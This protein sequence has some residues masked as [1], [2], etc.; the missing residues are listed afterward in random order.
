MQVPR[1]FQ[2]FLP[3]GAE[4]VRRALAHYV[5]EQRWFGGRVRQVVSTQVNDLVALASPE[6]DRSQLADQYALLFVQV[7][8]N[9]G[10]PEVYALPIAAEKKDDARRANAAAQTAVLA[11]HIRPIVTTEH[12]IYYEP[13]TE[14][15]FWQTL[16][17]CLWQPVQGIH[18]QIVGFRTPLWPEG[19]Q[20]VSAVQPGHA[21]Q[22][23]T[24]AVLNSGIFVKLF[25]RL[26]DGPNPDLEIGRYLAEHKRFSF[27]PPVWGG[28]EYEHA[29]GVRS[30]I[31]LVQRYLPGALDGWRYFMDLTVQWLH[32]AEQTAAT[33]DLRSVSRLHELWHLAQA[34]PQDVPK[35]LPPELL[36]RAHRLGQVTAW[37]HQALAAD[38]DTPD[39]APER[40]ARED[41]QALVCQVHAACEKALALLPR[42]PRLA[43]AAALLDDTA[44][45][46]VRKLLVRHSQLLLLHAPDGLY[47][48]RCHGDY[49]LGQVLHSDGDFYIIDFEGEPARP[50][51]E[52]RKKQCALR[53]VAGM[54]RSFH[55]LT[56][57]LRL[58]AHD[59]LSPAALGL[60]CAIPLRSDGLLQAL[61][62]WLAVAYLAGYR[63]QSAGAIFVPREP[64]D[65][66]HLVRLFSLEKAAYE[67]AYEMNHR[68]S[69]VAIPLLGLQLLAQE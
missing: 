5:T 15:G 44:L 49:H 28:L 11:G 60:S 61:Y 23:N 55:Y 27:V 33:V 46:Q 6:G 58:A 4:A 8:Y 37:L 13:L 59:V 51:H 36:D 25:R 66:L 22:T 20:A 3:P 7:S 35:A 10:L 2:M 34:F 18:G 41:M 26:E 38:S 67:F 53:D 40:P 9:E 68:P 1:N 54:V 65:W 21:Q 19:L 24:A 39:F 56:S 63:Q 69:W 48:I 64:H 29:D 50:L 62:G 42:T 32:D 47:L 45:A 12:A 14:V 31:A 30:S 43:A 52:R 16:L 57:A 17:A